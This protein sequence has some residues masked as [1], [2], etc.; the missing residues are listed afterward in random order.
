MDNSLNCVIM[1]RP[2]ERREK[3]TMYSCAVTCKINK[4][5]LMKRFGIKVGD[6]GVHGRNFTVFGSS[7][8]NIKNKYDLSKR[9]VAA[10]L[11][12]LNFD[13]IPPDSEL[14]PPNT[15][16]IHFIIGENY[17]AKEPS[18]T[19]SDTKE[20]RQYAPIPRH[21]TAA[22]TD[23]NSRSLSSISSSG[24]NESSS[25]GCWLVAA[26]VAAAALAAVF[27]AAFPAKNL[28]S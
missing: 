14:A 16:N 28:A 7:I 18:D 4:K 13:N 20:D 17:P 19:E 12:Y 21:E 23:N 24:G 8:D 6:G 3:S 10:T 15:P 1:V 9:I 22:T 26:V 5:T 2:Y 27:R 11:R 25:S